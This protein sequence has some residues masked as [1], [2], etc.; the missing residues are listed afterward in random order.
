[1]IFACVKDAYKGQSELASR[2]C[3]LAACGFLAVGLL[4][5]LLIRVKRESAA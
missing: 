5:T 4:A 2:Y 1:M 3:F